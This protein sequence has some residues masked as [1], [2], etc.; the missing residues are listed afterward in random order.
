M[1]IMEP[2]VFPPCPSEYIRRRQSCGR[3]GDVVVEV[4]SILDCH[5]PQSWICLVRPMDG[6]M[7]HHCSCNLHDGPD[8]SLCHTI[9]VVSTNSSKFDDLLEL[10]EV[11]TKGMGSEATVII[12]DKRLGHNTMIP[13][14]LFILF[15]GLK[16]LV[17]VQTGLEG[18]VDI[19]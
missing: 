7:E 1:Q 5:W 15:L 18:N 4:D 16:S 12:C 11:L 10:G 8:A 14:K 3:I 13:A 19:P 17:A 9:V 6:S 2:L